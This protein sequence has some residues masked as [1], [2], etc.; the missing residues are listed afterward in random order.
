MAAEPTLPNA[1]D[2]P[3]LIERDDGSW[4]ELYPGTLSG[5]VLLSASEWAYVLG[6]LESNERAFMTVGDYIQISQDLDITDSDY[7]YFPAEIIGVENTWSAKILIDDVEFAYMEI[8]EDKE[9]DWSSFRVPVTH[10]TGTVNVAI[11][12]TLES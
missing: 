3:A 8:K 1:P 7:L 11:R 12:L 10:L 2:P 6:L 5:R 9:M 4:L